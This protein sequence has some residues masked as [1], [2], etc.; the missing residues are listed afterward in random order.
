MSDEIKQPDKSA[1]W[2]SDGKSAQ[3]PVRSRRKRAVYRY[4]LGWLIIS[5]AALVMWKYRSSFEGYL[6]LFVILG[7]IP[8]LIGLIAGIDMYRAYKK[9]ER[10]QRRPP[11]PTEKL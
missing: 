9:E 1:P 10:Q 6:S 8:F 3:P 4:L 7:I 2:A 5:P 11:G